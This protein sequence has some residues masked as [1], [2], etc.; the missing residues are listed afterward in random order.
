[1]KR[2]TVI[3]LI[4]FTACISF[5]YPKNTLKEVLKKYMFMPGVTEIEELLNEDIDAG[6]KYDKR[7]ERLYFNEGATALIIASKFGYYDIVESLIDSEADINRE[8]KR[9]LTALMEASSN[10]QAAVVK[11]LIDLG[12]NLNIRD[13]N[14]YTALDYAR[15]SRDMET[16]K[17]L[18][19]SGA[20]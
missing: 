2:Q 13:R 5:L 4:I 16:L 15:Q 19:N 7:I 3:T 20:K 6:L 12:A 9:G 14:G 11:L 18:I 10:A 1:M 17:I 8:D